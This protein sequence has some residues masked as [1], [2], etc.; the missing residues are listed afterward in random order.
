M[1]LSGVIPP[2]LGILIWQQADRAA[3]PSAD[4][5]QG[6]LDAAC[7]PSALRALAGSKITL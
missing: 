4:I 1:I 6:W 5:R 2:M 3:L 7:M